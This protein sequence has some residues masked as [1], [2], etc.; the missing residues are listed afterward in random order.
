[1]APQI[2]LDITDKNICPANLRCHF[3]FNVA[4]GLLL[5]LL[6]DQQILGDT[7]KFGGVFNLQ[8]T[9]NRPLGEN[10]IFLSYLELSD[11]A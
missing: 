6:V 2:L 5:N 8:G 7:V 11:K 10:C 4:F 1:M 9:K 3:K